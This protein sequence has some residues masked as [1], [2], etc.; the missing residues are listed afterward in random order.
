M[1]FG[2]DLLKALSATQYKAADSPYSIGSQAISA[3]SP[4]LVNPYGSTGSNIAIT[5]GSGMLAALLAGLAEN[6][7]KSQNAAFAPSISA[8]M[9]ADPTQQAQLAAKEPR[10]SSLYNAMLAN[11][12][13]NDMEIKQEVAKFNTLNP[14]QTQAEIA[15]R[16]QLGPIE[17]EQKLAQENALSPIRIA[18]Q[19]NQEEAL[20]P[21]K[22]EEEFRQQAAQMIAP[23]GNIITPK[24]EVIKITNPQKRELD[25][26]AG[27]I[28]QSLLE[29]LNQVETEKGVEQVIPKFLP[30]DIA[31]EEDAARTELKTK[32][33]SVVQF[34]VMQK[35]LPLLSGFKDQDTKSSD[36]GFVFNYVK[37]NDDG[38]VRGEEVNLA[39]S[40]NPLLMKYKKQIEGAINGTSQLTPALK[41]QM[42]SEL[43]LAQ[44]NL[45]V[46]AVKDI[47][48]RYEIAK[49]RGVEKIENVS[50]LDLSMPFDIGAPMKTING[51]TYEKVDGG[52]RAKQ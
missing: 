20:Q 9:Q 46:Q 30:A 12:L 44:K 17:L 5:A 40:S 42:Y 25:L 33:P 7:A 18:E 24:G 23:D 43:K 39:E 38:A 37:A 14:L 19:V 34:E 1:A 27:R 29:K 6:D 35:S 26:N 21:L 41:N 2:E 11:S 47:Q 52:W 8:F 32:T 22:R 36:F 4:N 50:P 15:K 28:K 51:I 31:K 13:T 45:Y 48:R 3:I 10:L 49:G 16:Q